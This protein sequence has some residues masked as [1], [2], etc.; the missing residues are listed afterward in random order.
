M[1]NTIHSPFPWYLNTTMLQNYKKPQCLKECQFQLITHNNALLP[2]Q[3]KRPSIPSYTIEIDITGFSAA[4]EWTTIQYGLGVHTIFKH[5]PAPILIANAAELEAFLEDTSGIGDVTVTIASNIITI[6]VRNANYVLQNISLNNTVDNLTYAFERYIV[7]LLE[8]KV[9]CI[10]GSD[11]TNISLTDMFD[12]YVSPCGD[13]YITY[14]GKDLGITMQCGYQ[15]GIISDG[16]NVWY[17][18]LFYVPSSYANTNPICYFTDHL[19]TVI[20]T[21]DVNEPIEIC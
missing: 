19:G 16:T 20:T 17:S 12:Y 7:P 10:D 11:C 18:E 4:S 13:E 5:G 9:C 6:D 8:F 14:Y 21:E 1:D 2:F 15:M 3:V